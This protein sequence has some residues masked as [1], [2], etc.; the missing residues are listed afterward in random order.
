MLKFKQDNGVE[1]MKGGKKVAEVEVEYFLVSVP[2]GQPLVKKWNL[3]E[4]YSFPVENRG[5]KVT[6]NK[7]LKEY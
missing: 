4:N 5:H 2:N 7:D 1:V 6:K 3:M